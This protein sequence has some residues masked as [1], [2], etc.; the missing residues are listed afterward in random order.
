MGR[1]SSDYSTTLQKL[2]TEIVQSIA[3]PVI[4]RYKK[5]CTFV[6][7]SKRLDELWDAIKFENFILSFKNVLAVEAHKKLTKIFI[8]KQWTLKREMRT[9]LIK[10]EQYKIENEIKVN[11]SN[12]AVKHLVEISTNKINGHILVKVTEIE[13]EIVH[14]FHCRGCGECSPSVKNRHLLLNNEKEFRDDVQSLKRA[15]I[16]ELNADME[17]FEKQ[18]KAEKQIHDL[19]IEMDASLKHKLDKAIRSDTRENLSKGRLECMFNNLWEEATDDILR[20]VKEVDLYENIQGMVQITIRSILCSD[21]VHY[22]QMMSRSNKAIVRN[23]TGKV[24]F[25][26][27]PD[28]HMKLIANR[29][30]DY[31]PEI[32]YSGGC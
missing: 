1:A 10:R 30:D 8:E 21:D 27:V 15:L 12:K 26:I 28:K 2:K 17:K 3:N 18:M 9:E 7:L 25:K 20:S 29:S 4:F 23:E 16:K 24:T 32:T 5:F 31:W 19:S 11:H 13:K 14:Y 22:M 6:Q